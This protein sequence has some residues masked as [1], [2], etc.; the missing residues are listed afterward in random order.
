MSRFNVLFGKDAALN[1]ASPILRLT[2]AGETAWGALPGDDWTIFSPNHS[3]YE[4][5][6]WASR[7]EY[8]INDASY[9][10]PL[11]TVV[12]VFLKRL[13]L[14]KKIPMKFLLFNCIRTMVYT[15]GFIVFSS[16]VD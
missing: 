16:A 1:A 7:N 12:Q 13:K 3:T 2:R 5:L 15:M 11:V 10:T 14:Q 4:A 9:K 6:S 8:Y